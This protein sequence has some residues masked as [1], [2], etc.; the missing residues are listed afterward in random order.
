MAEI[1]TANRFMVGVK[2]DSVVVLLPPTTV[3]DKEA[4]LVFAAYLVLMADA[5]PGELDFQEVLVAV[6]NT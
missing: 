6:E 4:A 1:N 3:L 5:V 2:G